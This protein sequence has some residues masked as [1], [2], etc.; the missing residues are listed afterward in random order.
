MINSTH[1]LFECSES[2]SFERQSS[3]RRRHVIFRLLYG[4]SMDQ[5]EKANTVLI[6]LKLFY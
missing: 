5:I 2:Q 1:P 6:L 4:Y 3:E